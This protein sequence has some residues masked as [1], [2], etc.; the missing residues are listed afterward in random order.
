VSKIEKFLGIFGKKLAKNS[1][2]W[3]FVD[4][5]GGRIPGRQAYPTL[6]R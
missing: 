3:Y 6:A 4:L 1:L 5:K 2:R